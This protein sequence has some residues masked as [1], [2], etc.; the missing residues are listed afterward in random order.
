MSPPACSR[1]RDRSRSRFSEIDP[2][3]SEQVNASPDSGA[4]EDPT[5]D[6]TLDSEVDE[7]SGAEPKHALTWPEV[8]GSISEQYRESTSDS[9]PDSPSARFGVCPWCCGKN[10][11][12]RFGE[13]TCCDR[14]FK[15]F[16][17]DLSPY[18]V[19]LAFWAASSMSSAH[20]GPPPMSSASHSFGSG[21]SG[22]F[23]RSAKL[24]SRCSREVLSDS[25]T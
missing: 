3:T 22:P 13:P 21:L 8:E 9:T 6:S 11:N 7:S 25:P 24:S 15:S 18:W 5:S 17:A 16:F 23:R 20:R 1:V 2:R 19:I 4:A 10:Q 14:I 12:Q